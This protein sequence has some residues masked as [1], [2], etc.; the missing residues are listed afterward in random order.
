MRFNPIDYPLTFTRPARLSGSS[1][2]IEHIP[3][4]FTLVEMARPRLIVELGTHG[5]DS[6]CAFC[7]AV[8]RLQLPAQCVAVDTWKGDPHAG[9]Y[10]PAVLEELRSFHDARYRSFSTLLRS[11]FDEAADNFADGTIDLLHVDGF[12]TYEAV[13][14]DYQTWRPKLSDASVVL[15][16]DTTVR[17]PDFGVRKL[18]QELSSQFPSFNFEHG[19]GLGVLA[20]GPDQ[21]AATTRFFET[22]IENPAGI[23]QFYTAVGNRVALWQNITSL[24]Q[25]AFQQLDEGT[26]G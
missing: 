21:P 1:A 4:A 7:E 20:F 11:E 25:A 8:A 9:Y 24:A 17:R 16:H 22:A 3:F 14:H 19:N 18:W 2:W 10:G 12:H 15:F 26:G 6:Y 5:G 13:S 23:R